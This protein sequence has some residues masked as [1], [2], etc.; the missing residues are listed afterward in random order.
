MKLKLKNIGGGQPVVRIIRLTGE[1]TLDNSDNQFTVMD[2]AGMDFGIRLAA[3][4][5]SMQYTKISTGE[6]VQLRLG[7]SITHPNQIDPDIDFDA[8]WTDE[9]TEEY[10]ARMADRKDVIIFDT[11]KTIGDPTGD[12]VMF[13]DAYSNMGTIHINAENINGLICLQIP[14]V[15]IT[16]GSNVRRIER[17][18]RFIQDNVPGGTKLVFEEGVQYISPMAFIIPTLEN[19][20]V[21]PDSLIEAPGPIFPGGFVVPSITIGGGLTTVPDNFFVSCQTSEVIVREGVVQIGAGAFGQNSIGTKV[22]LPST[23]E[24]IKNTA[25]MNWT[26]GVELIIPSVLE[27]GNN[28]FFQ[29]GHGLGSVN[30]QG[31]LVGE[32]SPFILNLPENLEIADVSAFM[33]SR[34]KELVFNGNA[35]NTIRENC[36]GWCTAEKITVNGTI[37]STDKSFIFMGLCES[38]DLGSEGIRN[39]GDSTFQGLKK[40]T[41]LHIPKGCRLILARAFSLMEGLTNLTFAEGVEEL[42]G[43]PFGSS[44]P[45]LEHLVFPNSLK[46]FSSLSYGDFS[47][48]KTMVF[49]NGLTRMGPLPGAR[50][51]DFKIFIGSPWVVGMQVPSFNY[52]PY[53]QV[54]VPVDSYEQYRNAIPSSAP[55]LVPYTPPTIPGVVTLPPLEP[56]QT[57]EPWSIQWRNMDK[58]T[59][60]QTYFENGIVPADFLKDLPGFDDLIINCPIVSNGALD[61]DGSPALKRIR[62]MEGVV[63]IHADVLRGMLIKVRELTL[64]STL[65]GLGNSALTGAS[66][67]TSF[68]NNATAMDSVHPTALSDLPADIGTIAPVY[69]PAPVITEAS[70]ARFAGTGIRDEKISYKITRGETTLVDTLIAISHDGTWYDNRAGEGYEVGD[71]LTAYYIDRMDNVSATATVATVPTPPQS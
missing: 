16:I 32:Q 44:Y 6:V 30:D 41:D 36:F 58:G 23:L 52:S 33:F 20:L 18:G 3:Q 68:T 4:P 27:I 50:S 10:T 66:F 29:W 34:F 49:G 24:Y 60:E 11:V 48:L 56:I 47:A 39:I 15:E 1:T 51:W 61:T 26:N 31:V 21:L 69:P 55:V 71:K 53:L 5:V 64:P 25:F 65:K 28:A 13:A 2:E 9:Q 35:T 14:D 37:Q 22:T 7:D 17:S 38:I 46:R 43:D 12:Y 8:D 45:N 59:P 54:Y 62:I 40:I 67:L 42:S 19:A 63:D 70:T 57:T